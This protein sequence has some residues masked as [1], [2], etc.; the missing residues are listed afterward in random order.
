MHRHLAAAAF[1]GALL[2]VVAGAVE[3]VGDQKQT[4]CVEGVPGPVRVGSVGRWSKAASAS[5]VS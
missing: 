5:V 1:L 4:A 3:V 2:L